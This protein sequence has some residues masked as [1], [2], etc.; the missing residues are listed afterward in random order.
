MLKK[1]YVTNFRGFSQRIG[2]DFSNHRS[3]EFNQ[4]AIHD[5]IIKNGILYGPNGSGK[6]NFSLA[7]FDIVY[8][9]SQNFKEPSYYNNYVYAGNPQ[10]L[11][12]FSYTFQFGSE[13]LVYAYAKNNL[14]VLKEEALTVNGK[15]VFK[16]TKDSLVFDESQYPV[17]QTIK[18][19][20]KKNETNISIINFFITSFP[21]EQNH[22]LL[23]LQKFVS[24]MLWFGCLEV[25]EFIGLESSPENTIAYILKHGLVDDF[26]SFLKSVS[27][28]QFNF[29][30]AEPN[31]TILYC[32]FKGKQVPFY[33]IASTGTHAL[34]LLYYWMQKLSKAS[35]VFIDEFDA[36]YHFQLS[37]EVCKQLFSHKCQVFLSSHNTYLMTNDLLRPDCNFV[38]K[39]NSIH[40]ICDLTDKDLRF[41]HNIEKLYRGGAFGL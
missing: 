35:F 22:Y 24:G 26:A 37:Y 14:G 33:Q 38:I 28:Q 2:I 13:E 3:Y 19:K 29:L 5:G 41:G 10:S 16:R 30:P 7:I 40:P 17:E 21:L 36:F 39:D 15:E 9:L 32:S 18:E 34:V 12:S 1:F 31:G 4:S 8:H 27:G 6:T 25:R 11:V 23:K 20:L